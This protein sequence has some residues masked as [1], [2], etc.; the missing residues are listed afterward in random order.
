MGGLA[1]GGHA[2]VLIPFMMGVSAIIVGGF[3]DPLSGLVP[4]FGVF[5]LMLSA[6]FA[7]FWRDPD[8][9]IPKD[10]GVIISPADGHVMFV[11]RERA[12][13][14]RPSKAEME[15]GECESDKLTG[16]WFPQ[17]LDDVLSF[18]GEQR[19]EAV[20]KGEESDSDVWRVA[21]FMSPLDV[22]VNRSP[23][24]GE[25]THMEHRTGKGMRRGP[26]LPAF[27]KES[28]FNERVRTVFKREEDGLDVEVC[29]ISGALARTIVPWTGVGTKLR[30]G[31][32]FGMI[33]LGSRVD[34]RV[35]ATKFKPN[36][37]P[38]EANDPAHPKGQ[39]VMA[40]STILYTPTG[41]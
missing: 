24:K 17:P 37:I 21:V 5:C 27:K 38:A 31:E 26:F 33:R 6:F 14:R 9:K 23:V 34:V 8:R 4:L 1:H 16:D 41:E 28:Q 7:N 40:G 13:G 3:V 18:S 32:R 19:F 39:F 36:V 25:I 15:S 30:R 22:H 29:Q 10:E 11:R 12:T 2:P 20:P 35:P